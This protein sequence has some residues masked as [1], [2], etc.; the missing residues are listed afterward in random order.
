MV[1]TSEASATRLF[2]RPPFAER[3]TNRKAD[4]PSAMCN[5]KCN[6]Y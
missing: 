5:K 4:D 6:N 2:L 3:S 1:G